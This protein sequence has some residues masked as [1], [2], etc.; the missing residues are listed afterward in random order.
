MPLSQDSTTEMRDA[1]A[2]TPTSEEH[3][4]ILH[5]SST[6]SSEG[7][8]SSPQHHARIS[9]SGIPPISPRVHKHLKNIHHSPKIPNRDRSMSLGAYPP[10]WSLSTTAG[11]ANQQNIHHFIPLSPYSLSLESPIPSTS[12]SNMAMFDPAMPDMPMLHAGTS[13]A[14]ASGPTRAAM[15]AAVHSERQRAKAKE[16]EEENMSADELRLVLKRER[17]RMSKIQADLAAMRAAAVQSQAEAEVHEEGR[18]NN[19]MRRVECLQQEKGRIIVELEREEEMVCLCDIVYFVVI[20]CFNADSFLTALVFPQ[21]YNIFQL[22]NTLQKKLDEVKREK[23]L[24]EQQIESEQFSHGELKNKLST[25]H[26]DKAATTAALDIKQVADTVKVEKLDN[27]VA[28]HPE[29]IQESS[30]EED[31]EE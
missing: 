10:S 11:A 3:P 16:K 5:K 12:S 14:S 2:T 19:L 29:T 1:A 15:E 9:T 21:Q 17:T 4:S 28:H 8:S 22:T 24:L 30:E 26:S 27:S 20:V 13:S 7:G 23:L 25:I 6:A 31:E 18:I